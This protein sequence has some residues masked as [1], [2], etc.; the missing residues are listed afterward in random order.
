[1][2]E[3]D[4]DGLDLV[5]KRDSSIKKSIARLRP[6]WRYYGGKYR[7][8][9]RYPVP[10]HDV[11]IEPFAGAAG[12]SMRYPEKQ[13]ILIEKYRPVWSVWD[14]LINAS[15]DD[16]LNVPLVEH[17]DDVPSNIP[18]GARNLVGFSLN[19]G[20]VSPSRKLSAGRKELAALGR[21]FE[22]WNGNKREYISD[23]VSYIKHWVCLFGSYDEFDLP[24]TATY[25][26]DPPYN[27][28]AGRLY[29][30][31]QVDYTKL[32]RYVSRLSGQIIVC[33]NIGADWLPFEH[34]WDAKSGPKTRVSQEAMYYVKEQ[35]IV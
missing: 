4:F 28:R 8:A 31:S 33:E 17:I 1:M 14:F 11:I 22:G 5:G 2:I 12:Y 13:V 7:L 25:F 19:D 23:Q 9:P 27:S 26:I 20:C 29:K 6:F 10:I 32:S 18:E 30:E 16:V 3:D 24:L 21:K 15:K 35:N 34:F